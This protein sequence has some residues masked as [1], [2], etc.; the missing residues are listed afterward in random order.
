MDVSKLDEELEKRLE[1]IY[2]NDCSVLVYT[3]SVPTVN[4]LLLLL[5]TSN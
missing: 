1:N 4:F 2:S 3:V 5:S